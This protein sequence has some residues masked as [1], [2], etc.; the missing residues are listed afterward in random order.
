[1]VEK[2]SKIVYRTVL[3]VL[4]MLNVVLLTRMLGLIYL[5]GE[6]T[7][8]EKTKQGA[9]AAINYS[10]NLAA[11]YGVEKNKGVTDILARFKYEIEKSDSA[12]EVTSLMLDYGRQTQDIIFREVQNKRLQTL[13]SIINS[14]ELPEKG[15]ITLSKV[16]GQLKVYDPLKILTKESKDSIK[17]VDFN[18]TV[19]IVIN[20]KRAN[21][22][23][24]G[25]IFNQ[26]DYLQTKIASLE[27][28]LKVITQ[29]AGYESITGQG[30]II[31]LFDNSEV[32]ENT[33]II[34]DVDIRNLINELKVAG[35]RGIEVGNQRLT[36]NS[37]IRCVGP[38]ILVNNKPIQVNPVVIKAIGNS[39]VLT[40]SLDIIKNQLENFGIDI[41]IEKKEEIKLR[42]QGNYEG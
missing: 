35:A 21:I 18:Q 41:K 38:T 37:A 9:Q 6:S 34:H 29:K 27:R 3:V 17:N 39:Q 23:T 22:V 4:M 26:V 14:Q 31:S 20:N 25:D 7:P 19:E 33:T 28:Q 16:A 10:E 5:P 36:V 42:G 8:L 32:L 1:M 13:L 2:I 15:K 30:I 12:E 24:V 40:S 11:S